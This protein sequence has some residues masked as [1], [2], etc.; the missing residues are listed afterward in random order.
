MTDQQ[1]RDDYEKEPA[2]GFVP[3]DRAMK[4]KWAHEAEKKG[5][6]TWQKLAIGFGI[7]IVLIL[8]VVIAAFGFMMSID[9]KLAIDPVEMG[10]LEQALA[11]K[12]ED[13]QESQEP[14]YILVLGSDARE[15]D[16]V[17]RS[18]TI[19]LCRLDPETKR[20]SILSIPRDTKVELAGYGTQKINAAMAYGGPA[21]A[22]DAVSDFVGVKISHI[23]M[24][25]FEGFVDVVDELGGITINVPAYSSYNGIELQP[26][27]QTLNGE[28]AL[29]FV[30]DRKNYGL[31]D[32]QRGANQRTFLKAVIKKVLQAPATDIPGLVNSL[33]GGART[34]LT[35]T[36]FI[37]LALSFRG[38]DADADMYVGQ[39]PSTT[40]TINGISYVIA[41]ED[42]WAPVRENYVDGTVP[43]VDASN[44]PDF[45]E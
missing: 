41:I 43:F 9:A 36:Q 31:G 24:I 16:T 14:Y 3:A 33:A 4:R 42:E 45:L 21:G 35:T 25:D 26:G 40:A 23:V 32:F 12:A 30:R 17:S 28:Q 37:D 19:M 6:K 27:V 13:P 38:M 2:D 20:V 34:D 8:A 5:L 11:P 1:N 44:Q 39:V 22:V 10:D 18:D 29:T 15:G 7:P